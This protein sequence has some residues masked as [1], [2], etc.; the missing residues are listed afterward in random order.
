MRVVWRLGGGVTFRGR[1]RRYTL[2]RSGTEVCKT[3]LIQCDL[4]RFSDIA[5]TDRPLCYHA[6]PGRTGGTHVIES[7][8]D[9]NSV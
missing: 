3:L 9:G 1:R 4:V 8:Q 5:L 7:G 6:F 2:S